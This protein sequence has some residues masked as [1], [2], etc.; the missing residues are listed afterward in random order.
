MPN[1][2]AVRSGIHGVLPALDAVWAD[3]DV[4]AAEFAGCFLRARATGV[5]AP[6][7]FGPRD[8]RTMAP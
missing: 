1:R 3:P 6:T 7:V 5:G 2:T 4:A 8:G